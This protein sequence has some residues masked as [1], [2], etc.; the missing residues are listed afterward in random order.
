M[1]NKKTHICEEGGAH[2]KKFFL[3]FTDE[4]K[5]QIFVKKL[6]KWVNKKQNKFNIYNVAFF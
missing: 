4:L 2:L 6:L 5:K 3:A 1:A